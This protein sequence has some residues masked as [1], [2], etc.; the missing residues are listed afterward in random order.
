[1]D[2]MHPLEPYGRLSPM[3][4]AMV[5][6][7]F[8]RANLQQDFIP[9]SSSREN[10][11]GLGLGWPNRRPKRRQSPIPDNIYVKFH[12]PETVQPVAAN[13]V[14]IPRPR[15]GKRRVAVAARL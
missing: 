4:S 2:I 15:Q 11:P 14:P 12:S 1:M 10:T 9:I 5:V 3:T 8:F 13:K 7:H 6:Y